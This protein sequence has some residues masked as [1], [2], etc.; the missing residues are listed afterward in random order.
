MYKYLLKTKYEKKCFVIDICK[1]IWNCFSSTTNIIWITPKVY[2][3]HNEGKCTNE[4]YK[5]E[6]KI[7]CQKSILT[8]IRR[9]K[10]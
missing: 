2:C 9:K 3:H 7:K 8:P 1:T 4:N 10:I 6:E 5:V